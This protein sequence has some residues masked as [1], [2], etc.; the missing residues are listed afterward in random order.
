ML[1]LFPHINV[2]EEKQTETMDG[3]K[4]LPFDKLKAELFY[5]LRVENQDTSPH[6]IKMAVELANCLLAELHGPNKATSNYLS[7]AESN[8]IWIHTTDE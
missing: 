7:S 3:S 8:F 6:V 1:C 5:P 4:L 2:A